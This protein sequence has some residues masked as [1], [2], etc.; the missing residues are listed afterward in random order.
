MQNLPAPLSSHCRYLACC[1]CLKRLV[2]GSYRSILQALP[3]AVTPQLNQAVI[4][5]SR[6]QH[7]PRPSKPSWQTFP[8]GLKRMPEAC[9]GPMIND[10]TRKR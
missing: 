5:G 3:N 6:W 10:H 7:R 4:I 9:L 8:I 2:T 1:K